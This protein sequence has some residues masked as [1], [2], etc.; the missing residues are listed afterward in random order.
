MRYF[1]GLGANLGE[2]LAT[3]R[4]AVARL[5]ELG[6]VVARSAVYESA[7]VGGP[8][9]PTYLNA[10]LLLDSPLAPLPLLDATQAIEAA[11]GRDRAREI[12][13]GPRPIDLDLLLAGGRGELI[14]EGPRLVL[15][16]PRLPQRAFALAPLCELDPTL[17]HPDLGR[18][19]AAL[20]AATAD[21]ELRPTGERL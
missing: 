19:L 20:L 1:L 11:L 18:P 8:P 14:L 2:R 16:H 17:V 13:F 3:L 10:A 12:R 9:Q 4:Q 15:P 5:E 7:P 6:V 21:Q